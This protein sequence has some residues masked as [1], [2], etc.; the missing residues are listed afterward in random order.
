MIQACAQAGNEIVS[1]DYESSIR[2]S[3]QTVDQA[4]IIVGS[5]I[6]NPNLFVSICTGNSASKKQTSC[7]VVPL[8]LGKRAKTH[9]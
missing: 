2:E 8:V 5:T 9:D 7:I 3:I 6:R 1:R 4:M